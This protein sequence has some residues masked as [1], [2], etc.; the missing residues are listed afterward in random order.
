MQKPNKPRDTSVPNPYTYIILRTP[1]NP[2]NPNKEKLTIQPVHNLHC[3]VIQTVASNGSRMSQTWPSS[4]S[5]LTTL[6][7]FPIPFAQLWY[8]SIYILSCGAPYLPS[9]PSLF[10][11]H[12]CM[13]PQLVSFRFLSFCVVLDAQL[14][15]AALS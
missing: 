6:L 1:P 5:V 4:Q 8:H 7:K 12:A 14:R 11:T 2:K 13:T 3:T 10:P 15:S 9:Q